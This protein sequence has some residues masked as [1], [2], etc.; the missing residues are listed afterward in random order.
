MTINTVTTNKFQQSISRNKLLRVAGVGWLFDA[1]DVGILSFV[2][3][4]LAVEWGLTPGQSGWIGSINSIG[5]AVGALV[6]G[7]LA[8][9]VGR[10]QIF[11]WT[12]VLFSIA[13]GLSAFTTTLAA[14]M[15]L[16]FLVGMGLG[17]EL[18][19]ASTLVSE[20]V[21]AKERGRVVVLLESFWAA[22]WLIAALIS[23]FVIPSWGWRSALLLT[24]IP[25]IYAI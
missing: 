10:K 12:L 3:A 25:A 21:E 9:K 7:V 8:D 24:A 18:P 1:M 15:T 11:M 14:F 5:M 2:I 17:G 16:R 23:Y 6:F 22:G 19:V 13:S 4:A 20:S